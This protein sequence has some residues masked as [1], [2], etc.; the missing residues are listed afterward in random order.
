MTQKEKLKEALSSLLLE[1]AE[2]LY[3]VL[4]EHNSAESPAKTPSKKA[5]KKKPAKDEHPEQVVEKKPFYLSSAYQGWYTNLSDIQG[6]LQAEMFD[7]ELSA[8]EDLLKK[9]HLRAA[10]ALCGVIPE[11]HFADVSKNHG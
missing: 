2:I 7:D 9:Q 10:G 4:D 1:G 6:V 3:R 5:G 11:R 8:A